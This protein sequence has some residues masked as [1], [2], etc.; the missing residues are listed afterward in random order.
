M[1]RMA[2][3]RDMRVRHQLANISTYKNTAEAATS[4][5]FFI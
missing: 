1:R 2:D 3:I 4:A 5:V